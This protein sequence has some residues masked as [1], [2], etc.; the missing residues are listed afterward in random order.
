MSKPINRKGGTDKTTKHT[1][2]LVAIW[3]YT[4][5]SQHF[6]SKSHDL[7]E[8]NLDFHCYQIR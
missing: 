8:Q 4:S 1:K 5:G 7:W 3:G 2:L 6:A